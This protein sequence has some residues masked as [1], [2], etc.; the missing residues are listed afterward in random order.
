MYARK[1]YPDTSR[2]ARGPDDQIALIILQAALDSSPAIYS[3]ARSTNR[4]DCSTY[5]VIHY[6]KKGEVT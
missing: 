5:V 1:F 2:L 6:K 3:A 4:C